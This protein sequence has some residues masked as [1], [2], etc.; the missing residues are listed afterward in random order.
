MIPS[1][2]SGIKAVEYYDRV[3]QAPPDHNIQQL[4]RYLME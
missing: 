2:S 4:I 1:T 3:A